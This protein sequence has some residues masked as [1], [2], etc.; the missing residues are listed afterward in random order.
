M[1]RVDGQRANPCVPAQYRPLASIHSE[2]PDAS[3]ATGNIQHPIGC[4]PE[5]SPERAN[6]CSRNVPRN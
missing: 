6:A 2:A 5:C 3:G 4:T 1:I